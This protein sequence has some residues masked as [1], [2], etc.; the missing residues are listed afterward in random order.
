VPDC[1]LKGKL[2]YTNQLLSC[3]NWVLIVQHNSISTPEDCKTR[4]S[5]FSSIA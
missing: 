5:H 4:I 1:Q 2:L 3:F